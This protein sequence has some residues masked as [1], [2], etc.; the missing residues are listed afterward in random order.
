MKVSNVRGIGTHFKKENVF[1]ATMVCGEEY[2]GTL[3]R[4][5]IGEKVYQKD[6]LDKLAKPVMYGQAELF[7]KDE[8]GYTRFTEDGTFTL[9]GDNSDGKGILSNIISAWEYYTEE[10]VKEA[11]INGS[12]LV[13]MVH[14]TIPLYWYSKSCNKNAS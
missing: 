4:N 12:H 8:N 5:D 1:L 7:Y 13:I 6:A 3:S 11:I 9:A 14:D 2:K 10:Q